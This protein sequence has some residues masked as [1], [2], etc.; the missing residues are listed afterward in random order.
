MELKDKVIIGLLIVILAAVAYGLVGRGYVLGFTADGGYPT[1][2]TN[3][4]ITGTLEV[5][6]ATTLSGGSTIT[7]ASLTGATLSGTTTVSGPA[8]LSNTVNISKTASSTIIIGSTA[9]G[10]GTGCI[11]LGDSGGATS[12]PVYITA[13]GATITATT[14]RPAICQ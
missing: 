8:V 9:S 12:T 2:F 5:N 11:K 1:T 6:G 3:L 10:L 4:G 13:T 14:T 7:S